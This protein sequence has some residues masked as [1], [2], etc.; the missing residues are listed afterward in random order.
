MACKNGICVPDALCS[1]WLTSPLTWYIIII[2]VIVGVIIY[3]YLQVPH[4]FLR[5]TFAPIYPG[6]SGIVW[7][8]STIYFFLMIA[9]LVG[10]WD[11]HNPMSK[12]MVIVYTLI[13]ILTVG[14]VVSYGETQLTIS[15][16]LLGLLWLMAIWMIWLTNPHSQSHPKSS[17]L[18]NNQGST[19]NNY[20]TFIITWIYLLSLIAGTYWV[21]VIS[22]LY[23]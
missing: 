23:H 1:G 12:C 9:V 11:P 16:I 7:L 10:G 15:Y 5:I 21:V 4:W 14:W 20:F 8:Y 6:N 19:H 22:Q 17:E 3:Y 18:P 13:L 2:T